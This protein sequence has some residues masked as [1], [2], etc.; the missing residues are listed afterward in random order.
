VAV[1]AVVDYLKV[2]VGVVDYL[3]VVVLTVVVEVVVLQKAE[4][5]EDAT[6]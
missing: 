4:V 3:K 2:V 6:L 5:V 1:G